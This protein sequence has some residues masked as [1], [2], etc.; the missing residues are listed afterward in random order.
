MPPRNL[1]ELQHWLQSL[2]THPGGI[3]AAL[4]GQKNDLSA[5]V[6]PSSRQTS[7]ERLEV[8][9]SAYY[10]RLIE[11]LREFFPCLRYA[12]GDDVFDEFA[13]SY[14]Q[15]HPPWSYTLHRLA[16]RFADF[17]EETRLTN[18]ADSGD[19]TAFFVDLA[20]LEQTIEE[21]FDAE[22]PE[23]LVASRPAQNLS[24]QSRLIFVPGFRLLA[25]R[26]PVSSY[27][28]GWKRQA[29]PAIPEPSPQ[30]IALFRRDYIVRR[31][32]LS[33]LQVALLHRL[34]RGEAL[35]DALAETAAEA[36][37]CDETPESFAASIRDWFEEWT[38][39]GFFRP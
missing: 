12:M 37:A 34:D 8:Y 5:V 27:Y 2:L 7:A 23:E 24:G 36:F 39:A 13:V 9:A 35:D 19:W 38:R 22:G 10:L 6:L 3:A 15:R 26:F 1:A 16:D 14:L 11:C 29:V 4:D 31:H 32:E 25:F 18:S 21:V 17:L 33:A 28:T 30:H 20:R